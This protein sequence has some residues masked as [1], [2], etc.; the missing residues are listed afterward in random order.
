MFEMEIRVNAAHRRCQS[1]SV[2]LDAARFTLILESAGEV[3]LGTQIR[4]SV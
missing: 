2:W 4:Q 3:C 1:G